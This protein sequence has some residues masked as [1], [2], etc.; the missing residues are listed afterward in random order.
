MEK[1]PVQYITGYVLYTS[2]MILLLFSFYL[3]NFSLATVACYLLQLRMFLNFTVPVD[4]SDEYVRFRNLTNMIAFTLIGF[5]NFYL[6]T[7][8]NPWR[9]NAGARG[10]TE[11]EEVTEDTDDNPRNIYISGLKPGTL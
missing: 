5:F 2:I 6:I 1:T 4:Y 7:K 10:T 9:K 3:D 8:I 11:A